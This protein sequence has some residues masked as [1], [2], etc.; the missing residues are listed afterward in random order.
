MEQKDWRNDPRL[1]GMD[2]KKLTYL[3]EL[4]KKAQNTPKDKLLPL[5]MS[6]AAESGNMNFSNEETDLIV[7]IL[8]ANMNPAQKK[9]VETLRMLSQRLGNR[10]GHSPLHT[11]KMN[12]N[13]QGKRT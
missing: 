9:Q 8:T 5:F 1:R 6:L 2:E 7:S 11:Q 10:A 12:Q 4:A 3:T 13:N